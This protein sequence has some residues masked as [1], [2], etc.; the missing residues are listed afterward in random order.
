MDTNG[1]ETDLLCSAIRVKRSVHR[2]AQTLD[3]AEEGT[4]W[5]SHNLAA[6]NRDECAARGDKKGEAFWH[7][8]WTY[9]MTVYCAGTAETVIVIEPDRRRG[10]APRFPDDLA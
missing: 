5:L 1:T 2:A 6:W 3:E 4:A 7:E 10:I 8:V 9:L